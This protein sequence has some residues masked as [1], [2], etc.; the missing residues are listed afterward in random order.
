MSVRERIL[1]LKLLEQQ[2]KHHEFMNH[3]GIQV[4][5]IE[6]KDTEDE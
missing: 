6:K 1:A 4:N 2:E 5:L 3:I